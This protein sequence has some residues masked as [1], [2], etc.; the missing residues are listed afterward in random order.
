MTYEEAHTFLEVKQRE[1]TRNR[2]LYNKQ[3]IEING[4]AILAL[5]KQIPKKPINV[6]KHYYEC[7]CCK[8]DLGISDDDIFV[9]DEPKPQYC[10]DC[11]QALDWT[12]KETI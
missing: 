6:E 4:L 3:A 7:P 2:H 11:G 9:Y 5:E 12:N 8:R 10:S 1:M